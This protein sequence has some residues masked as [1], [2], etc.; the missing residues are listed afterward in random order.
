MALQGYVDKLCPSGI[1]T[2]D[3]STWLSHG[4]L[5]SQ[6]TSKNILSFKSEDE[7]CESYSFT[8]Y[9]CFVAFR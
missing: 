3:P 2:H 7:K 6:R 9:A 1:R 5:F 8:L 4:F